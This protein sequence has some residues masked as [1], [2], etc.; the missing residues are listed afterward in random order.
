MSKNPTPGSTWASEPNWVQ[1]YP[2]RALRIY[3]GS[4]QEAI[5][6]MCRLCV[7]SYTEA[8][9]CEDQLCPL[10]GFRPGGPYSPPKKIQ[11]ALDSA[12][13]GGTLEA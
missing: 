12:E 7:G 10:W 6:Q 13:D 4:R 8:T 3:G 5:L 2:S 11:D 9:K 1:K